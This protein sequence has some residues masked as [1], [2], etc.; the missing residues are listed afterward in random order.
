MSND[1]EEALLGLVRLLKPMTSEERHR[2]VNAAMT[3]VGEPFSP[4]NG[5][6]SGGGGRASADNAGGGGV[7]LGGYP[8]AVAA[9]MKQYDISPEVLDPII[10]FQ[11]DGTFAIHDVPGKTKK[12]QSLNVYTLT[13]V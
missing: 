8:K 2:A 1:S 4:A 12:E 7:D 9:W 11:E 5:S 13:G 3:Y 10:Q 6:P